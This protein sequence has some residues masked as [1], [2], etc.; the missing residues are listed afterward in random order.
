MLSLGALIGLTAVRLAHVWGV[1][2]AGASAVV[3][4][5]ITAFFTGAVRSPLTGVVLLLEMTGAFPLLLPMLAGSG[6]AYVLTEFLRS[7]PLYDLLRRRDERLERR[8]AKT[9]SAG[10]VPVMTPEPGG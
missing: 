7:P 4:V 10:V 6:A 9:G 2:H 3:V 5:S 1:E 8:R